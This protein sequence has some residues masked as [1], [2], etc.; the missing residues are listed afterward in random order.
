MEWDTGEKVELGEGLGASERR[1]HFVVRVGEG[2]GDLMEWTPT[3][4]G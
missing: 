2:G 1:L 4:T 3:G